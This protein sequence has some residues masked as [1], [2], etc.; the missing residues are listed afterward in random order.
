MYDKAK[1]NIVLDTPYL[2]VSQLLMTYVVKCSALSRHIDMCLP[3]KVFRVVY[4]DMT[5]NLTLGPVMVN[6]VY[7]L[8]MD[9]IKIILNNGWIRD[10][11]SSSYGA[12]IVL[13]PKIYQ[14]VVTYIKDLIW[15]IC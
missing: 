14:E 9:H 11:T 3:L 12:P 15:R 6:V 1:P 5:L 4:C 2:F 8:V 13:T 10:C 7:L